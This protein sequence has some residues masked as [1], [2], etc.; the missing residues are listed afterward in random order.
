MANKTIPL[1]KPSTPQ[2]YQLSRQIFF[3][4]AH[5][6]LPILKHIKWE[7]RIER[8]KKGMGWSGKKVVRVN[9]LGNWV[10]L[11]DM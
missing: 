3:P 6:A 2:Q 1:P 7:Y 5:T 9:V 11:H 10:F 8:Q 4:T